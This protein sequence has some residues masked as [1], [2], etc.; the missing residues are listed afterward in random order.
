MKFSG[1]GERVGGRALWNYFTQG[2]EGAAIIMEGIEIYQELTD[3]TENRDVAV[4][5]KDLEGKGR[6]G[7]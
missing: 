1:G 7:S 5:Q 3:Y 2:L 6:G 4:N